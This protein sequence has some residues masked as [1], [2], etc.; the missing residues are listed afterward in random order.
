MLGLLML[1]LFLS[2][3]P[4]KLVKVPPLGGP[5]LENPI[6]ELVAAFSSAETLQSKASIRI[7]AIQKGEEVSP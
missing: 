6:A 1:S 7:D 4:K 5:P 3:C 2:G